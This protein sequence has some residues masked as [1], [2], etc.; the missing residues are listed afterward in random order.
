MGVWRLLIFDGSGPHR[1][2]EF[3]QYCNR[4]K[5]ICFTLPPYTSQVFQ[6]LDVVHCNLSST[7]TEKQ[8]NRRAPAVQ[9]LTTRYTAYEWRHSNARRY[10][11]VCD[12]LINELVYIPWFESKDGG[13]NNKSWPKGKA[14]PTI[15]VRAANIPTRAFACE[16]ESLL[17]GLY[18]TRNARSILNPTPSFSKPSSY[19]TRLS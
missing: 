16:R 14:T 12:N 8:L 18:P 15:L 9:I 5:L 10:R 19:K 3:L 2:L 6:P 4:H 17:A 13:R 11:V 7:A 1:T